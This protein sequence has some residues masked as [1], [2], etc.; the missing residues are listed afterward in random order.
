VSPHKLFVIRSDSALKLAHRIRSARS[1]PL[2]LCTVLGLLFAS[3][4]LYS[5]SG[6]PFMPTPTSAAT[7]AT[8]ASACSS[9]ISMRG[10]LDAHRATFLPLVSSGISWLFAALTDATFM[11]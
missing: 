11:L 2:F 4:V 10:R 5:T 7:T 8:A 9:V 1:V 6:Y 3:I